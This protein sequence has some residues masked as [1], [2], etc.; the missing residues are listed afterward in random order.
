VA[1]S[2][3][4]GDW[5]IGCAV[6][7]DTAYKPTQVAYK[8][9]APALLQESN[10]HENSA[11]C[12]GSGVVFGD[13]FIQIGE[14]RLG[15]VD[16][17]H[18]S[19]SHK[20]GQTPVIWRFDGRVFGGPRTDLSTWSRSATEGKGNG[21]SF[22]DRFIQIGLFR[23]GDVDGTHFSIVRT[24]GKTA[25]VWRNDGR[26]FNGPRTDLDTKA[27]SI[28]KP[29]GISIGKNFVQIG[30]WRIGDADGRHF[31]VSHEKGMVSAIYR[32]DGRAF[33]GPRRDLSTWSLKVE[34]TCTDDEASKKDDV[35][36][37]DK[38]KND[39]W[40]CIPNANTKTVKGPFADVNDA[41]EEMNKSPGSRTNIQMVCEM[42]PVGPK[43]D[44]HLV[45][46][47]IQSADN[48]FKTYWVNWGWIRKLNAMC[49]GDHACKLNVPGDHIA[50][51][52]FRGSMATNVTGP[53]AS[54][55]QFFGKTVHPMQQPKETE[56]A[57]EVKKAGE[58]SVPS[59]AVSGRDKPAENPDNA[60]G[61]VPA[62]RRRRR[63]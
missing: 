30:E 43:A 5:C 47:Q 29:G 31:S 3:I 35:E 49:N 2:G 40:F 50:K 22:G 54:C 14:W 26:I 12:D 18:L 60:Q 20:D 4:L 33:G 15:D 42:S 51:P 21:I 32:E 6:P 48:G 28:G 39:V 36:P 53:C 55:T 56:V 17:K 24:Q 27:R 7:V 52:L 37:G 16:G 63:R 9:L 13:R 44:P 41:K 23:I 8:K 19:L 62:I 38:S 34:K 46:G 45:G 61:A 10:L 25:Q 57:K 1:W 59:D 58:G 11:S